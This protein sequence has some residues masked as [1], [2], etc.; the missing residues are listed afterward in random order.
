MEHNVGVQGAEALAR[1]IAAMTG[2]SVD[3]AVL[4]EV[5][6]RLEELEELPLVDAI[7]EIAHHCAMLPVHDDRTPDEILGY[8][9]HGLPH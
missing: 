3:E 6:Q 7:M 2:E 4:A 9:E 1:A 8:D 5:W